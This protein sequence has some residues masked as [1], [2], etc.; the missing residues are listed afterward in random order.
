MVSK[1]LFYI[2]YKGNTEITSNLR[3]VDIINRG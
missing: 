3:V 1:A 2:N